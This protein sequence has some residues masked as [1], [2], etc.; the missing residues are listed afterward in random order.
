LRRQ[1]GEIRSETGKE[2]LNLVTESPDRKS[3]GT[4]VEVQTANSTEVFSVEGEKK[5]LC[6]RIQRRTRTQVIKQK[7]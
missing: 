6:H 7:V 2:E 4:S 3:M 1:N 5:G